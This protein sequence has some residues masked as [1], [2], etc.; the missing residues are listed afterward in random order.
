M[1]N[2]YENGTSRTATSQEQSDM[3]QK[4]GGGELRIT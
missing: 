2:V 4:L 1:S 3:S